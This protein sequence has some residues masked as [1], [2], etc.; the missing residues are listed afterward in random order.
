[1]MEVLLSK[2]PT[3]AN[4]KRKK[5][6]VSGPNGTKLVL[7]MAMLAMIVSLVALH[8]L[9]APCKSNP[10]RLELKE[11]DSLEFTIVK[12]T[13]KP[14]PPIHPHHGGVVTYSSHMSADGSV[15]YRRDIKA[16]CDHGMLVFSVGL[17]KDDMPY[18]YEVYNDAYLYSSNN[19]LCILYPTFSGYQVS[20]NPF[21]NPTDPMRI[22]IKPLA[23]NVM[24]WISSRVVDP[25]HSKK[26]YDRKVTGDYII[27]A[28]HDF[29][30]PH[31]YQE[32]KAT[33]N[34]WH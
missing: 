3:S 17:A 26:K 8:R 10:F 20:R 1:M 6:D 32:V 29:Y 9:V 11:K 31:F 22:D 34:G 13:G 5:K 24:H 33:I 15:E 18:T 2:T 14:I 16:P 25:H 19:G 30:N 4:D 21:W 23:L 12:E 28:K 7:W 27:M